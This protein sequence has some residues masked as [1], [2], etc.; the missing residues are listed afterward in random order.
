MSNHIV[1]L[2]MEQKKVANY[3]NLLLDNMN[4]PTDI[5]LVSTKEVIT[6]SLLKNSPPES[7]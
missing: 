7:L 2:S 3:N 4:L 6:S 5:T 1:I